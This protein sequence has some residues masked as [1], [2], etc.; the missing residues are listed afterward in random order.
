MVQI[1]EP[2]HVITIEIQQYG[3]R[4]ENNNN[5]GYEPEHYIAWIKEPQYKGI[6]VKADS[7]SECMKELSISL[8]VLELY[9]KNED[10]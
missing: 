9:R 6:I 1:I 5:I 4:Y 8:N 7:I 2:K 3:G 10:I